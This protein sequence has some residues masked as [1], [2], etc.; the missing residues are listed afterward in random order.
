ML[1]HFPV[2]LLPMDL[3][4]SLLALNTGDQTFIFAGFYALAGA[5]FFGWLSVITGTIDLITW[6]SNDPKEDQRVLAKGVL[7]GGLQTMVI[8]VYTILAILQWQDYP[9]LESPATGVVVVKGLLVAGML[10]ANYL[11]GEL[12]LKHLINKKN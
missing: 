8:M 7:H 5:V 4:C 10:A 1:V 2:A 12:V 11:G 9:Y 3:I 6:K